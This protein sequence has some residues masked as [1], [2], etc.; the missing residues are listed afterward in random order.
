MVAERH[1]GHPFGLQHRSDGRQSLMPFAQMREQRSE[2]L[3][4]VEFRPIEDRGNVPLW[5]DA[6]EC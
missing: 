2:L 3:R 4:G 5:A 6:E 1:L